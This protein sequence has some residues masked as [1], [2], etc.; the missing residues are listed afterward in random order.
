MGWEA[1]SQDDTCKMTRRQ[2]GDI[3]GG[4]HL[5]QQEE[6]VHS[7][8]EGHALDLLCYPSLGKHGGS[9]FNGCRRIRGPSD[10]AGKAAE[11]RGRGGG[12]H[13]GLES[14]LVVF[15]FFISLPNLK[16]DP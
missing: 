14:L 3:F 5:G 2:A 12:L 13:E 7:P 4:K 10:A 16:A 1:V 11:T 8:T 6:E 15:N 9:D